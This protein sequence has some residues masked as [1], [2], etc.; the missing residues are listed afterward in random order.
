MRE[1]E[2]DKQQKNQITST[3][4]HRRPYICYKKLF[5]TISHSDLSPDKYYEKRTQD[6]QC[7]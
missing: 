1:C 5:R 6:T 4:Y 3:T 2:A 7:W